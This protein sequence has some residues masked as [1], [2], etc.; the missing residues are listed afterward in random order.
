MKPVKKILAIDPGSIKCG[1]AVVEK[2]S[3]NSFETLH[4]QVVVGKELLNVVSNLF[5][6]YQPDL[7]ILGN[8][9]ASAQ[10]VRPLK[11][12]NIAPVEVVNEEY[13]TIEARRRYFIENPPKGIRRLIPVSLQTPPCPYDD[14][15]A[16]V[17]SERHF[18]VIDEKNI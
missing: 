3:D 6:Q 5:N 10:Y 17:L 8:G 1:V 12:M 14:Y 15:V 4:R 9:T 13:S 7:I 11:E 16:V 18:S 2:I